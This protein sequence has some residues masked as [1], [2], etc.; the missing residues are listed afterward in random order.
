MRRITNDTN[1]DHDLQLIEI[2]LH[3][4]E[5]IM[6]SEIEMEDLNELVTDEVDG[7]R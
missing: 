2:E 1:E 3:K 4:E 5:H 6:H 7:T